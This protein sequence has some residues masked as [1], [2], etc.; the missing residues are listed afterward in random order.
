MRAGILEARHGSPEVVRRILADPV[1]G[2]RHKQVLIEIYESFRRESTPR[3]SQPTPGPARTSRPSPS[4]IDNQ[5]VNRRM[6]DMSITNDIRSYADTA[7]EQGKQYVGQ[8]AGQFNGVN[9]QANQFVTG[10]R[11]ATSPS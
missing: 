11:A 9:R 1:L 8:A 5:P 6:T 2:E 10:P 3:R 4:R 7:L